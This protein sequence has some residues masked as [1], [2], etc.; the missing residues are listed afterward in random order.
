MTGVIASFDFV[1]EEPDYQNIFAAIAHNIA[2]RYSITLDTTVTTITGLFLDPS[3]TT[4]T[5]CDCSMHH[6]TVWRQQQDHS[7]HHL[8]PRG[9]SQLTTHAHLPMVEPSVAQKITVWTTVHAI[10]VR[11]QPP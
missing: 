10:E 4:H 8:A 1:F 5:L 9:T 7:L 6:V 3:S 11:K 2:L